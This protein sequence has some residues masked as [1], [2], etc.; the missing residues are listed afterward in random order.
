MLNKIY[1]ISTKKTYSL[2][3]SSRSGFTRG[4]FTQEFVLYKTERDTVVNTKLISGVIC[5]HTCQC[6]SEYT[7]FSRDGSKALIDKHKIGQAPLPRR[8]PFLGAS[9]GENS[10]A[11]RAEKKK[12]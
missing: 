4:P 7:F 11:G 1:F 12:K 3:L 8:N 9:R 5:S 10:L 2:F 6:L